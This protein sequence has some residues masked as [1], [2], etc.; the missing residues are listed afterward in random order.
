VT[1]DSRL[2]DVIAGYEWL[3]FEDLVP[4]DSPMPPDNHD[5]AAALKAAGLTSPDGTMVHAPTREVVAALSSSRPAVTGAVVPAGLLREVRD[6]GL[7]YWEP[8]TVRGQQQKALMLSRIEAALS[9]SPAVPGGWRPLS[10][11]P[12]TGEFYLIASVE[13]TG[14]TLGVFEADYH[15]L[16]SNR[17]K[18][19]GFGIWFWQPLPAPPAPEQG[20][21]T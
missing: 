7:I 6:E 2:A 19:T 1:P 11:A 3:E 8:N 14:P 10:E 16:V 21:T 4:K 18:V 9:A 13:G 20:E 5:P 12:Q 17:H 15:R